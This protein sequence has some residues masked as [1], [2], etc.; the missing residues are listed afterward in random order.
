MSEPRFSQDFQDGRD[1]TSKKIFV[2]VKIF[3]FKRL[4]V[5]TVGAKF[6]LPA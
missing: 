4:Y 1:Y 6:F 3:K 2:T 5:A